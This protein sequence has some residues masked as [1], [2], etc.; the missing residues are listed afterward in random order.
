MRDAARTRERILEAARAAF[1]RHGYEGTTVRGVAEAA[2]VAPNL[3]TRYFGGKHGLFR[4]ATA[5]QVD[6]ASVLPGDLATLGARIAR[7]VVERWESAAPE[8][9]LLMMLRS[10]GSSDETAAALTCFFE[11]EALRPTA[12]HLA[13]ELGCT[14]TEAMDRVASVGALITGVVT[15]RYVMRCGPLAATRPEVLERW[16]GDRLQRLLD[17]PHP[18]SLDGPSCPSLDRSPPPSSE[19]RDPEASSGSP[20][21]S[22]RP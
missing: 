6:V 12:R 3:I 15:M 22:E 9:P 19:L 1:S 17:G 10:S 5:G 13:G 11:D 8:D 20:E 18:P 4:A 14:T 21:L 7:N 16:L 2:G